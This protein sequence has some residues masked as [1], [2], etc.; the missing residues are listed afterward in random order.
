MAWNI[1]TNG[2]QTLGLNLSERFS[3][4]DNA[5]ID[6]KVIKRVILNRKLKNLSLNSWLQWPDMD[7]TRMDQSETIQMF[8]SKL[9]FQ[10]RSQS[11]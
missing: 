1:F 2:K 3:I 6:M 5:L 7:V 11:L 8:K 4:T 9:R 10:I